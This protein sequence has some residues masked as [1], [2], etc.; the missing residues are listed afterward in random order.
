MPSEFTNKNVLITGG[1]RGIG[2]ACATL[3]SHLNA[4]VIITYKSNL[5]EAK[6]TL[7]LLNNK[8]NHSLYQLDVSK[9]QEIQPFFQQVIEKYKKL[10][11]LVNNAGVFIEHKIEAVSFEDW[12]KAWN[13]TI[14]TNLTGVSNL[15]YFASQQMI[16]QNHGKIVNISSR[17]A[18][19]GEPDHPAYAAS[20]AGLNAMSQSLAVALGKHNILV[21]VIA[22]GFVETDMATLYLNNK[23]GEAIKKQSPLNRIATPEEVAR[24]VAVFAS[25]GLEFM[26]GGIVD[27]NGASYLRT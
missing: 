18:F 24:L 12:Q 11:V 4:N 9:P 8:Q 16:K 7:G 22:P 25:D 23:T 20:K 26:T 10:D 1:S 17:G 13:E 2:R 5:A 21:G 14:T 15:C 6:K 19:R 27:L 3:F